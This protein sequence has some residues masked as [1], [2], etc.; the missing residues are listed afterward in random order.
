MN[1]IQRIIEELLRLRNLREERLGKINVVFGED[2][3][4]P[5]HDSNQSLQQQPSKLQQYTDFIDQLENVSKMRD[6]IQQLEA[7]EGA[8]LGELERVYREVSAIVI[9]RTTKFLMI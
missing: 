5:M 7:Q 3:R 2:E 1:L 9:P 4:E 6:Q 8:M